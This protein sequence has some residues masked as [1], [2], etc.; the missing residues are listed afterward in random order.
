[1]GQK[2]GSKAMNEAHKELSSKSEACQLAK[3]KLEETYTWGIK[4]LTK[5]DKAQCITETKYHEIFSK[6]K[7]G[8][9]ILKVFESV[10]K[11]MKAIKD[12]NY[13][14]VLDDIEST[15]I[16]GELI[17]KEFLAKNVRVKMDTVSSSISELRRSMSDRSRAHSVSRINTPYD[18]GAVNKSRGKD[19][20]DNDEEEDFELHFDAQRKAIKAKQA[21]AII[22]KKLLQDK[23][24]QKVK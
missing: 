16:D 9:V 19:S 4:A 21:K 5:M 14:K 12:Q 6:E 17:K 10:S 22:Q 11:H 24:D 18:T 7:P 23:L 3:I 15:K 8:L 20:D 2:V 13:G 1:M